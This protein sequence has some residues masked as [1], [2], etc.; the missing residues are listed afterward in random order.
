MLTL[1]LPFSEGLGVG[2]YA[3]AAS[4]YGVQVPMSSRPNSTYM[5][6]TTSSARVM[7]VGSGASSSQTI[8]NTHTTARQASMGI[9]PTGGRFTTYVPA[10]DA[11]GHAYT[12]SQITA[13]DTSPHRPHIRKVG[14]DDDED[15][16]FMGNVVPITNT[17]W[18]LFIL[19][20]IGYG[21]FKLRKRSA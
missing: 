13:G 5:M 6:H 16:P 17:P 14:H 18:I 10:I 2:S 8:I 3:H 7:S 20:A 15:D 9:V 21:Y 1:T 4:P 11:D 12:P 19:L